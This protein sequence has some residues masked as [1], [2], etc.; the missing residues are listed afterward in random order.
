MFIH[1]GHFPSD[2][3]VYI[4]CFYPEEHCPNKG[5]LQ[6]NYSNMANF[7]VLG[8]RKE[9]DFGLPEFLNKIA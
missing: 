8:S 2:D 6:S 7:N 5:Q 9:V 4:V 3:E 1:K